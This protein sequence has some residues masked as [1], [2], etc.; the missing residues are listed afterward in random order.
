MDAAASQS[1]CALPPQLRGLPQLQSSPSTPI[2]S[3]EIPKCIRRWPGQAGSPPVAPGCTCSLVVRP[4]ATSTT[5]KPVRPAT[6]M[7][8][9]PA[10]HIT[11][12]LPQP[13]KEQPQPRSAPRRPRPRR[14]LPAPT[15][16][17]I[18]DGHA[19]TGELLHL[20]QDVEQPEAEDAHDVR[21]ERQQEEEEVAVVAPPDAV[22]DPGAVVVELLPGMGHGEGVLPALPAPRGAGGGP[23]SSS[24]PRSCRRRCSGSSAAGGRSGRSRTTSCA[25]GC[26]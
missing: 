25:P 1:P 5:W 19:D 24:P 9:S 13:D 3:R 14:P 4:L 22:V 6:G 8:K 17:R 16:R 11:T 10:T 26:P 2:L 23:G 12:I 18:R 21:G 15:A 20:V 7:K